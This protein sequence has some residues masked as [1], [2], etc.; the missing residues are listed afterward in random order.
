MK[1][2]AERI[3]ETR[4]AAELTQQQ[5]SMIYNIPLRTVVDWERGERTP[6]EYLAN[7]MIRC[8]EIDFIRPKESEIEIQEEK[9]E[10][11]TPKTL[12]VSDSM[13][14]PFP[15]DVEALVLQAYHNREVSSMDGYDL[16]DNVV[17]DPKGRCFILTEPDKYGLDFG[18]QFYLKEV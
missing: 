14:R 7:F 8:I 4:K 13:G 16:D 12:K 15:A 10:E 6:P 18:T 11:P 9:Q 3:K 1:T 2:I 17:T 5:L